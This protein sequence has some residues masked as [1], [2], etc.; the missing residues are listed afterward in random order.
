MELLWSNA[1]ATLRLFSSKAKSNTK[2]Y[3]QRQMK[4]EFAAKAREHSY[5]ARSAF[6]LIEMDD[7]FEILKPGMTVVDVGCAPGSWSQVVVER[8]ELNIKNASGYL[9]GADLQHVAPI[10][11]A[12]VLSTSDITSVKVQETIAKKLNGRPVNVVLSDMAPNPTGDS[13]TDHLR[14][15]N[16]CRTV[17]HLFASPHEAFKAEELTSRRTPLFELTADG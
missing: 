11:G 4:D 15:V 8:C 5:R 12:E 7:R 17:F 3:L 10:P 2:K 14:L 16:L 9:I 6:K 1:A 13:A